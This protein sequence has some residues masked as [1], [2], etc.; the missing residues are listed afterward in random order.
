MNKLNSN[1]IEKKRLSSHYLRT[2]KVVADA[3]NRIINGPIPV[4][5]SALHS[6]VL[7]R[8]AKSYRGS[9]SRFHLARGAKTDVLFLVT[10]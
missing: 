9:N 10:V 1:R 2:D 5:H 4:K 8:E 7:L 6:G 3:R